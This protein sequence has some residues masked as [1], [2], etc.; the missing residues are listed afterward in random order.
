F[1]AMAHRE[2]CTTLNEPGCAGAAAF[3]DGRPSGTRRL[4]ETPRGASHGIAI[5]VHRAGKDRRRTRRELRRPARV[6][7]KS[8]RRWNSEIEDVSRRAARVVL[9]GR[10][11]DD[12]DGREQ[13]IDDEQP[14]WPRKKIGKSHAPR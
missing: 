9:D 13:R 14:V 2:R 8:A 6:E 11:K 7:H 4:S 10:W 1:D 5:L 3:G 12:A